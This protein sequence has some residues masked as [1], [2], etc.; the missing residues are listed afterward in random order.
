VNEG[1]MTRDP[2][3]IGMTIHRPLM[4]AIKKLN[5]TEQQFYE[6]AR[7]TDILV[8]SAQVT[9]VREGLERGEAA[10]VAAVDEKLKSLG[11]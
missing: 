7:M 6:I 1:D 10:Y 9:A 4:L 3:E 8:A 2:I 11:L 5:P